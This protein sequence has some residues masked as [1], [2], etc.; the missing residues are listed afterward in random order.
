MTSEARIALPSE[1]QA[2]RRKLVSS[3]DWSAQM[4]GLGKPSPEVVELDE[5]WITGQISREE[6]RARLHAMAQAMTKARNG[7][8]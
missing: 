6:R 5:L 8:G 7:R 3:A 2:R 4:A 1:E